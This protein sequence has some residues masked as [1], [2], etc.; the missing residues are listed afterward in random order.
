[1]SLN[2]KLDR[3]LEFSKKICRELNKQVDEDSDI[4]YEAC[5]STQDVGVRQV[6][7]KRGLH[8]N[9]IYF[10][11]KIIE[12]SIDL[13][14]IIEVIKLSFISGQFYPVYPTDTEITIY[15]KLKETEWEF[16]I[17]EGILY[18]QDVE[19]SIEDITY[20]S[21]TEDYIEIVEDDGNYS[22]KTTIK[23]GSNAEQIEIEKENIQIPF[24]IN[25][26]EESEDIFVKDLNVEDINF[27]IAND[28]LAYATNEELHLDD[29]FGDCVICQLNEIESITFIA[30]GNEYIIKFKD[31]KYG[32][33]YLN[34]FGYEM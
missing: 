26:G 3:N 13:D 5:A 17:N 10:K 8:Y 23:K 7:D 25:F 1:M 4:Y 28:G 32:Y 9:Q 16:G 30:T 31:E 21:I 19:I 2:R 33:G 24:Y 11:D 12:K 22:Y 6:L 14:I 15:D 20:S 18:I 27:R 29:T 34:K